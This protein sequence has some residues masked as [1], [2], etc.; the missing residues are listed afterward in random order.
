[1]WPRAIE[2]MLGLWMA[3]SP[4]VF[5]KEPGPTH[6]W[7][8]AFISGAAIWTF[9]LL[10]FWRKARRAY[11]G[12]LVVAAWLIGFG[13]VMGSFPNPPIYQNSM[14]TG[15]VLVLFAIIPPEA[16]KPPLSW[17]EHY[18]KRARMIER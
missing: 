9:S 7:A 6:I 8:H 4:F 18:E 15:L 1:M 14:L 10:S 11:L 2:F 5:L 13:Y 3:A 12:N 17:R 16:T